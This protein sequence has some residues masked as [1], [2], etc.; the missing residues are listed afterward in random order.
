MKIQQI[1]SGLI[2][3]DSNSKLRITFLKGLK[4]HF[5]EIASQIKDFSIFYL[6]QNL[7]ENIY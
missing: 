5:I 4:L 3:V 2:E 1:K 7:L 6:Y